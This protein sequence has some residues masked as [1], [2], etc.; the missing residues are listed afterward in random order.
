MDVTDRSHCTRN[1]LAHNSQMGKERPSGESK[2]RNPGSP[3]TKSDAECN[4]NRSNTLGMLLTA[5]TVSAVLQNI[6]VKVKGYETSVD[7]IIPVEYPEGCSLDHFRTLLGK[8]LKNVHMFAF[9]RCGD[10]RRLRVADER[11][12]MVTDVSE[13]VTARHHTFGTQVQRLQINLVPARS[14]RKRQRPNSLTRVRFLLKKLRMLAPQHLRS[15][16]LGTVVEKL[17][18]L[19][20]SQ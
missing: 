2:M 20:N 3:E 1:T 10:S 18:A 11:F 19:T 4:E 14:A 15:L 12:T 7:L 6:Y 16:N 13:T 9:T 17:K 5:C 8:K